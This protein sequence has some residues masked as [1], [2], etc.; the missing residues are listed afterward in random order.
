MS[1]GDAAKLSLDTDDRAFHPRE[2]AIAVGIAPTLDSSLAFL[3]LA[4]YTDPVSTYR[5]RYK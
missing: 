4:S 5:I 2:V 1:V 3:P